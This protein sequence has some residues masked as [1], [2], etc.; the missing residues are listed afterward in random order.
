MPAASNSNVG[1]IVFVLFCP[2]AETT[3]AYH[4]AKIL[5]KNEEAKKKVGKDLKSGLRELLAAHD[6]R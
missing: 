5:E 6:Y 1:F 3:S 2:K 4:V